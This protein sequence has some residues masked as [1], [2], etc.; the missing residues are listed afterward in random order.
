MDMQ[1]DKNNKRFGIKGVIVSISAVPVLIVGIIVT[2]FASLTMRAGVE[3]QV[4]K[5]LKGIA[6][7][8]EYALDTIDSGDYN[9]DGQNLYKGK[10]NVTASPELLDRIAAE[11]DAEVTIFIGDTR[12]ATTITNASGDRITG[13]SLAGTISSKVLNS[14]EDYTDTQVDINGSNYYGYYTLKHRNK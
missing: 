7:S 2:I 6:T 11:N 13:T 8:V 14:G 12:R 5:G 4:F 1:K 9:Y 3:D 10:L